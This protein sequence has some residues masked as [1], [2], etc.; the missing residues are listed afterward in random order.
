MQNIILRLLFILVFFSS[1]SQNQTLKASFIE[2]ENGKI[3]TDSVEK[4]VFFT[5]L[6][7]KKAYENKQL[8]EAQVNQTAVEMCTNSGFE[9]YESI[10]G[11][12]KL[13]NF[14]YTI[15]DPPGPTQCRSITNTANSYIDI[16]N[17][18]NTSVMATTVPANFIDP[19]IG[20]IN[21][22]DQY[23]LKINYAN[24]STYGSIVQGKRFKTNNENYLKFNFKAVLMTVYDSGH[25][26]NQ[27]FIKARILNSSGVVINEFCLVGDESNCIFTKIPGSDA[28]ILYTANWQSGILDI[29]SLPNNEEFTVEF[30]ASRCGF[31]GHFGY[32]YVDDICF[33]HSNENIQGS[34]ELEPLNKVC[35]TLPINVCGK[36]T[37]PNSGGISATLG[38]ITLNLYNS[39]GTSIYTTTTTSSLNTTTHEFC[40]SLNASNFPNIINAN[41]NVGVTISYNFSGSSTCLGTVFN[42][43]ND[44]DANPGW[45]ISFQNCSSSCNFQ[46][47]TTKLSLCDTNHDGSENFNL[48]NA[49]SNIVTSVSGYTF[50]YFTS[51]TDAVANTN[52]ISNTTSYTSTS[53]TIYVRVTESTTCFKII[54]IQLE[55]KN[56]NVNITGILNVCSGSTVLN[57]TQGVNYLWNTGAI[58]Q[59]ITVTT[60]GTYSVTVTDINGCINTAS[61]TIE[62]SQIATTP[63]VI[64]T[65]PS[66]FVAT[67]TIQVTSPASQYSFD[68]GNTWTT[69]ATIGSLTP[70]TYYIKTKTINNCISYPLEIIIKPALTSYPNS[71]HVNPA[72]CGAFGSITITTSASFYS[73]DD[74]VTWTTN[75]T[76]SNLTAGSYKIRTKDTQGCISNFN[77]VLLSNVSLETPIFTIINP[78]CGVNGSI[79]INTVSDFYTFDGG[80]TWLTNNVLSNLT[81]GSYSIAIKNSLGCTSE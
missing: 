9:Q 36:Y 39:S 32:M 44:P 81:S 29:S 12:Q 64:I 69:N 48:T 30:M 58:S 18:S 11:A 31:G 27:P 63:D 8:L 60:I 70:G 61:V 73:F 4:R 46:I 59:S 72:Y 5:K 41:Y 17:P 40:F 6:H 35:S 74:G 55:V 79:T 67:G 28:A 33:L 25:T 15:G 26:D 47:T 45:D 1:Y 76:A 21:A 77:T 71:T 43:A 19:Y 54:P 3:L 62:P 68:N 75:P 51:F 23:A 10:S 56:P 37:I 7:L 49:N 34:I 53:K 20:D 66:C 65:Q 52:A 80:T 78:A 38:T 13:K 50:S 16:Y 2:D 24:S 22:F 57:A 42:N 14:L